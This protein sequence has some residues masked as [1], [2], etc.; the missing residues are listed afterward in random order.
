MK[1]RPSRQELI[2]RILRR[3]PTPEPE[4]VITTA[5]SQEQLAA[6]VEVGLTRH[7]LECYRYTIYDM[8]RS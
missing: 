7:P 2:D 6:W 4:P 1:Q 5:E 8:I 3:V